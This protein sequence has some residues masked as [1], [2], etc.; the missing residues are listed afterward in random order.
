MSSTPP[1]AAL[2]AKSIPQN[3]A[4][5]AI[6]ARTRHGVMISEMMD[7]AAQGAG[8]V[9]LRLDYLAKAPDFKRLFE[10]KP[11]QIITTI[12]RKPDGGKYAFK[13]EERLALLRQAIVGGT[14][15][16]DLE[17]DVIDK[18]PRYGKVKRIVSYHNFQEIPSDIAAIYE[19]M[20]ASDADI[21]KVSCMGKS[22]EDNWNI[23][24]LFKGAPKPTIA[25][26]MGEVGIP[27]RILGG[28]MGAPFAY[29]VHNPDRLVAPGLPS[30]KQLR[31]LY[32]YPRI[33]RD[34]KVFGVVGDPIGHSLSPAIHNAAFRQTGFNGVYLPFLVPEQRF[35][36]FLKGAHKFGI[37]GLSVTIPHKEMAAAAAV[38]SDAL[39]RSTSSA[40]TLIPKEQGW[41]AYN[42]DYKALVEALLVSLPPM[43]NGEPADLK[44]RQVLLLGA[45]GVG[46]SVAFALLQQGAIVTISNRTPERAQ[47]LA[48]ALNC[49]HIDWV[50][51]H[52]VLADIVINATSVG[53]YPDENES[54][55]HQSFFRPGLVVFDTVYNPE[56]TVFV[57]EARE[58][59]CVVITGLELFIRQAAAQFA[60]FTG[61]A[62]PSE[63]M[64][65]VARTALARISMG[66]KSNASGA[67][68]K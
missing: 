14:D 31:T 40:N 27:S 57:K 29:S 34:T 56:S 16:V 60:L 44:A 63:L 20:C 43:P 35:S 59:G 30:L 48:S 67:S 49:R 41:E 65:Q 61:K 21:V 55:L 2:G 6:V 42:T 15:W 50:T 5:C 66:G 8:M 19:K 47:R 13:E 28:I 62:A 12:R 26:C 9:E 11:C 7:A 1:P 32:N 58:R 36:E 22:P 64:R 37:K 23:L 39:V 4:L 46:R 54:P 33:N 25:F 17:W 10:K 52:N 45:G 51:R 38:A 24:E 3:P 68:G 53:M 18:I